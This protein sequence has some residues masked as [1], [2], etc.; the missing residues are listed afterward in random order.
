MDSKQKELLKKAVV[1]VCCLAVI[2]CMLWLQY[3]LV[4]QN[5]FLAYGIEPFH[6]AGG[7]EGVS[8]D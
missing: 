2:A 1:P 5:I 7:A 4:S 3:A 6:S 8:I